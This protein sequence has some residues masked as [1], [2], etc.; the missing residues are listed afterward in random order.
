MP[1]FLYTVVTFAAITWWVLIKI[2][3]K[4]PP[5]GNLLILGVLL[6]VFLAIASTVSIPGY[7][8]FKR[9]APDFTNLRVLYRR[10]LKVSFVAAGCITGFLVLR[11]FA[12]DT[13]LN[14]TLF[15]ILCVMIVL[16]F[17]SNKR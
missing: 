14:L 3:T 6:L 10:S 12:L 11:A 16:H 1:K 17:F 7:F 8:F 15:L 4:Y 5:E 9:K 2:V 13:A